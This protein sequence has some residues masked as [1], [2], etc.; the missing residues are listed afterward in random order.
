MLAR[1]TKGVAGLIGV[2]IG[3]LVAIIIAVSVVI[4][5]IDTT[6]SSQYSTNASTPLAFNNYSSAHTLINLAPLL[7]AVVLILAI[8]GVMRFIR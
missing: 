5:T 4:P 3:I 6:I 8:V 2:F 1:K 7:I